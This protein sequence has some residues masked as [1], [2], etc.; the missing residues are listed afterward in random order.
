MDNRTH[1]QVNMHTSTGQLV[2][3]VNVTTDVTGI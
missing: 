2:V 3:S 1:E